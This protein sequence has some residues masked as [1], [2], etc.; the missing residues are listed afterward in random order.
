MKRVYTTC[1]N[2]LCVNPQHLCLTLKNNNCP[3]CGNYKDHRAG[4]CISCHSKVH[5][6]RLG[7]GK[8]WYENSS[9]YIIKGGGNQVILQHR[10]VVEMHLGRKL[11][12]HEH[13][14]HIDGNRAN[15]AIENLMVMS[16]TEHHKL[17]TKERDMYELSKMGHAAKAKLKEG[18]Q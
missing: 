3:I 11:E 9:G 7:T 6:P 18:K 4:V 13:V 17:H 16:S 5:K 2:K 14:H 1:N 12:S 15:N 10:Y 8:G